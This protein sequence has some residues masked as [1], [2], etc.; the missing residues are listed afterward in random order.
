[1]LTSHFEIPLK[2]VGSDPTHAHTHT[3]PFYGPFSRTTPGESVPEENLWTS[4]CK[5]RLTE[6]DT[7]DHLAGRHSIG[8]NQCLLPPSNS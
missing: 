2:L 3:Q 8:T 7:H 1:M 5:G 4:W 6:A